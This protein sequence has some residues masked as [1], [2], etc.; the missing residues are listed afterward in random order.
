MLEEDVAPSID[1][2]ESMRSVGYSLEAAIADLIDNSIAAGSRHIDIDLEP[3]SGDYVAI[4][5]DGKG[6][7]PDAAVEALRLAG[8]VGERTSSD[9]GR[10][11]LGLKTASLSQ[12]RCLTV[13]TRHLG[14]RTAL[15]WDIDHIKASGR[16][17]LLRL[18]PI[19]VRKL[20]WANRLDLQQSGTLV[21]WQRLDLLV[22]DAADPGELVR[23]RVE[24]LIESLALVFHRY[25]HARKG[26][27]QIVVNGNTVKPLDPFL[28]S[29]PKTQ[30]SPTQKIAIG[31]DEVKVTAYTL[32][33][34]SGL[35]PDERRR[36]DLGEHMRE[37]QGF[38]IYR[39]ER[40]I[41]HGHWYGLA[42]MDD[43]SKQTRVQ[44]D[45]PNTIDYLWNLDIKK[46]RAEPPAS[47]KTELRRLMS[48]VIEK[49]RRVY[50]YRGRREGG[51][52]TV[53]LWEKIRERDGF[54]YEVNLEHPVVSALL[55]G[56]PTGDA[57][58]VLRLLESLADAFPVHDLFAEMAG[59]VAPISADRADDAAVESLRVFR[60][61][62]DTRPP[63]DEVVAML[64][65][66][67]PFSTMSDLDAVVRK[68]WQEDL[69]GTE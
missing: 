30:V 3:A 49:G 1:L 27:I 15:R 5:D 68:I 13:V 29:N 12:A 67:E 36:P 48:G 38:Y 42:R 26:G 62:T 56:L 55:S 44:V 52:P 65:H 8:S 69:D 21:L 10:F 63:V 19:E 39:N 60:D 31:G 20:P 14:E 45:V 33:H 64:A 50:T 61:S 41:S 2:L 11:G 58:R 23:Q 59:N 28:T 47:F 37:M 53:H 32:P 4:L 57:S 34:V 54:R 6:I 22:G 40:L 18:A 16:W 17:S 7:A 25:L 43:L 9:L 35:T 51:A 66:V 24:P 46:S